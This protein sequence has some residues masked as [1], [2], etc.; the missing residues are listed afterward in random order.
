[1]LRILAAEFMVAAKV[2]ERHSPCKLIRTG[3]EVCIRNLLLPRKGTHHIAIEY[4]K[5]LIV[6]LGALH[7][8]V[9]DGVLLVDIIIYIETQSVI[10]LLQG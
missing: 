3:A 1:M 9:Q 6:R 2:V 10:V 7:Q 4:D 8:N 5:V